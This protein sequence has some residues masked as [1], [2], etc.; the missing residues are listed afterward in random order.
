MAATE[1][2]RANLQ[3]L[4][5]ALG[6]KVRDEGAAID[7]LTSFVSGCGM[8]E[9]DDGSEDEPKSVPGIALVLGGKKK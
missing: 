1:S 3:A 8:G 5:D 6:V 2:Q 9:E 7:A 4:A